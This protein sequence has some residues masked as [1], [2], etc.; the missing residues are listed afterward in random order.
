MFLQPSLGMTLNGFDIA[1][2]TRISR[3]YFSEVTN[4]IDTLNI[5][6]FE[7]DNISKNR[8]SFLFEPS[9]TIRGGWKYIKLQI[10]LT[11]SRN[12]SHNDLKFEGGKFSIGLTFAFAQRFKK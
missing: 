8:N 1:L 6:Y 2:S 9:L 4:Q 10:Q 7:V 11:S 3:L 12:L 5:A